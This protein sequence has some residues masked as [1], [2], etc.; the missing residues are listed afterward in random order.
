MLATRPRRYSALFASGLGALLSAGLAVHPAQAAGAA[1]QGV[2]QL[3]ATSVFA[4]QSVTLNQLS[5][6]GNEDDSVQNRQVDWGD[7]TSV[8]MGDGT[9]L[10]HQYAAAGAYRVQVAITDTDGDSTGTFSGVDTVT[11]AKVGGTYKILAPSVWSGPAGTQLSGLTL[12][13]VP[14]TVATVKI[15]WGDGSTSEVARTGLRAVHTYSGSGT[16]TVTVTLADTNGDSSPLAVG[17]IAVKSDTVRPFVTI[18]TPAKSSKAS[19]WR[20]L[21]GTA[22]DKASGLDIA[23]IGLGQV[24]GKT[25]YYFNGKKW[26]KGSVQKA[27]PIVVRAGS[28]GTWSFKPAAAPTKGTLVI[29][30]GA[31]DKVGNTYLP[32]GKKVTLKS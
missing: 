14:A 6:S 18:T 30:T 11:V 27:E 3:G 1:A 20:T 26:V 13:G 23:L 17:T 10:K 19:S 21:H 28:S 4:G 16:R 24:R 25:Q 7:G 2:Y 15:G 5:L 12:S 8:T 22:G 29:W 31:R 9:S 32:D